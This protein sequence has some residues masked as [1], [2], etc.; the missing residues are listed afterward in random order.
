MSL[1]EKAANGEEFAQNFLSIFIAYPS[2]EE[3]SKVV[4]GLVERTLKAADKSSKFKSRDDVVFYHCRYLQADNRCGVYEDRPQFCR[5]Y[6]DT[7][8]VVMAPGC[9]F[10]EWGQACRAK[11]TEMKADVEQLDALKE[12]LKQLESGE[13]MSESLSELPDRLFTDEDKL[14][15]LSLILSLTSLNLTS[16]LQSFLLEDSELNPYAIFFDL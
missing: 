7:P 6:P 3:A 9:A 15:G 5:D 12:Q 13:S 11:Y 2:H 4:P 14:A 1:W 10:E 16:P 8:F